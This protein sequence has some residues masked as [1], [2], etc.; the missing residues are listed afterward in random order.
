MASCEKCWSDAGGNSDL[1]S[2]LIKSRNCTPEE[3]AGGY[4]TADECPKCHRNTI[5]I[6]A[7]VC[8]NCDHRPIRQKK[9]KENAVEHP[10]TNAG[11]NR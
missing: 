1:Y 5:H 8:M 3:Q 6:Y 7:R 2:K 4:E 11:Q 10:A 9:N